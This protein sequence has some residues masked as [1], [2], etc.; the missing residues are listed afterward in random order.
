MLTIQF[1]PYH[2]IENLS[3]GKRIRK[4]LELAK[5][6]KIVLLEGRL[7][8]EEET[9]LIKKTMEEIGPNFKGIELAVL[10]PEK[11]VDDAFIK[12]AKKE[13][14]NLLMGDRQGITVLGPA[15][16]I[17]DIKKDPHKIELLTKESRRLSKKR[18]N[19]RNRDRNGR[20]K[21]R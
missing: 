13:V 21:R 5:E 17:K 3:S 15:T 2:E 12:K 19:N 18:S 20:K 6:D 14:I 11:E 9:D 10:Y 1:V 4:L 16:I 8:R 7:K